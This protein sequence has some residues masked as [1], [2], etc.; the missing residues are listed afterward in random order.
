M[1]LSA[2]LAMGHNSFKDYKPKNGHFGVIVP[3]L[4]II[5]QHSSRCIT[6]PTNLG[7]MHCFFKC[8]HTGS[9]NQLCFSNQL[10]TL[11]NLRLTLYNFRKCHQYLCKIM[12]CSPL[13]NNRWLSAFP[14]Y[15][16][17]VIQLNLPCTL[18]RNSWS[19]TLPT[20]A[21]IYGY[22]SS[23]FIFPSLGNSSKLKK[24]KQ[25]SPEHSDKYPTTKSIFLL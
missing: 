17:S 3:F 10:V 18:Q 7:I 25:T 24:K 14:L 2:G 16:V 5:Q 15:P 21:Q 11:T 20:G 12:I 8:I 1:Y 9:Q 13:H 22:F 23:P 19:V 6:N 4:N